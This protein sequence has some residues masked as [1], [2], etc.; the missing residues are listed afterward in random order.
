MISLIFL[1]AIVSAQPSISLATNI[2]HSVL[3]GFD[4]FQEYNATEC[5]S[6]F[7]Q[8]QD[9]YANLN[10]TTKST[11]LQNSLNFT[12]LMSTSLANVTLRCPSATVNYMEMCRYHFNQFKGHAIG[13]VMESFLIG[14]VSTTFE[15][16]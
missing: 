4:Y 12:M 1:A 2:T 7:K 10:Y 13:D 14:I 8:L 11:G 3:K 9:D 6:S 16:R 15:I 5:F